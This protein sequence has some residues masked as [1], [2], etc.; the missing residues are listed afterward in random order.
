MQRKLIFLLTLLFSLAASSQSGSEKPSDVTKHLNVGKHKLAIQGYDAVAYFTDQASKIGK[1]HLNYW[2]D[3]VQYYF[4]SEKNRALFVNSPEKYLPQYGG[5]C[6]YAMGAT[7]EKVSID[8]ESYLI[9]QGKLYL[10]Y[11]SFF[12]DTKQKWLENP[13]ELQFKAGQNWRKITKK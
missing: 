6:A 1:K 4:S 3:G 9:D 7:G 10:F 8:P 13:K 12:N 11:H 2:H 5:W